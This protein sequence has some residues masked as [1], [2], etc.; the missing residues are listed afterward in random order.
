M[1]KIA[2]DI[3]KIAINKQKIYVIIIIIK[4]DYTYADLKNH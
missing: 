3:F 4:E 1:V 2:I